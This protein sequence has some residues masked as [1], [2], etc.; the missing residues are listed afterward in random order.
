M[1]T[2]KLKT[3]FILRNQSDELD[4]ELLLN[5]DISDL[6]V[7]SINSYRSILAKR[8]PTLNYS[9][10]DNQKFLEDIGIF[11]KNRDTNLINLTVAGLLFFG[12]YNSIID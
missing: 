5:Y 4:Y 6:D 11:R 3:T 9:E 10:M 12:K 2:K 8:Y 7:D 1:N